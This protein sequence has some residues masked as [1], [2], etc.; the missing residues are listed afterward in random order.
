[1]ARL[2]ND[3]ALRDAARAVVSE[4]DMPRLLASTV[5][6]VEGGLAGLVLGLLAV[7]D[8]EP[9]ALARAQACAEVLLT[10]QQP[11]EGGGAWP[12][13]DG[14]LDTGFAHGAAGI[15]L[16]L[17]RLYIRTGDERLPAAVRAAQSF[18]RALYSPRNGNW[19]H[20]RAQ[21][22]TLWLMA[23]CHGAPGI[24]L[25]RA[26]APLPGDEE[27]ASDLEKAAASAVRSKPALHDH[28]CCGSLGHA[29]VLLTVGR[30][31]D[32]PALV[33][34]AH[35]MASA[36]AE[37]ILAQGWSG[38]RTT[39]FEQRLFEPGFFRGLAGIGY[40]LL[41][42]AHPD[43]LPSVLGFATAEKGNDS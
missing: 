21:G 6:D 27:S 9:S 17:A 22:G 39:G 23:W 8:L 5:F 38:A 10:A 20:R 36:V 2:G 25:A 3:P 24:A 35:A 11:A 7:T 13:R 41:R 19:P 15:A 4:L 32:E 43:T 26:L 40:Q 29:D 16:A 42:V 30:R 31:R 18:E 33:T 34:Q 14:A 37:R 28:L 1:M 12:S